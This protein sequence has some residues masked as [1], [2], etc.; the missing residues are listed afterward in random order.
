MLFRNSATMCLTSSVENERSNEMSER[1][2]TKDRILIKVAIPEESKLSFKEGYKFTTKDLVNIPNDSKEEN[3]TFFENGCICYKGSR[4]GFWAMDFDEL[5]GL[6][7]HW[8][9]FY[10]VIS[11]HPEIKRIVEE[12]REHVDRSDCYFHLFRP[13]DKKGLVDLILDSNTRVV[14][15]E[16]VVDYH[17]TE[18]EWL[19]YL[20]ILE[21]YLLTHHLIAFDW[22]KDTVIVEHIQ[23]WFEWI[24]EDVKFLLRPFDPSD[25]NKLILFPESMTEARLFWRD[26][27][28][29]NACVKVSQHLKLKTPPL[30]IWL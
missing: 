30:G 10:S 13:E 15:D 26:V 3:I 4:N 17:S 16:M 27:L 1:T 19:P 20:V 25:T 5:G 24:T 6:V 8:P 11:S 21:D 22:M 7:T 14:L 9:L 28:D 12:S 23:K 29:I 18:M 2:W